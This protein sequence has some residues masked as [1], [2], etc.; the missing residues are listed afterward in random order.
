MTDSFD[1]EALSERDICSKYITPALQAT[2]WDLQTQIREELSFTAGRIMVQGKKIKRGKARRAD[3]VLYYK[4]NM[5]IAVIEAKAC[6]HWE[7]KKETS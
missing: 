6:K 7:P 4:P 5:P 2:G 1:K 3:Y